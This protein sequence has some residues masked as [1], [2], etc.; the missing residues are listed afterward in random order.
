MTPYIRRTV[1]L[2]VDIST[3][4]VVA[5]I[6]PWCRA[7]RRWFRSRFAP[8]AFRS[9]DASPI[10]SAPVYHTSRPRTT[11]SSLFDNN[12][13]RRTASYSPI[14]EVLNHAM[15]LASPVGTTAS[16]RVRKRVA[17]ACG[18]CRRRKVC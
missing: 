12:A 15:S 6:R 16:G 14:A 1:L 11:A 8:L 3:H 4:I 2:M 10:R 5:A 18:F 9:A 13:S 7:G 17:E